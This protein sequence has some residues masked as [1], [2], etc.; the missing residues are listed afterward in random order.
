MKPDA[1]FADAALA[2]IKW[3]TKLIGIESVKTRMHDVS[4]PLTMLT[5]AGRA[6]TAANAAEL[7]TMSPKM[8]MILNETM[9]QM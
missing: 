9:L 3:D 7:C 1:L 5:A 2:A 4:P 8:R 6:D